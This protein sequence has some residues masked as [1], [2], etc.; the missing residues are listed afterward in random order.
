VHH[1]PLNLVALAEQLHGLGF[2]PGK[3]S[4][5]LEHNRLAIHSAVSIDH[6]LLFGHQVLCVVKPLMQILTSN[7]NSLRIELLDRGDNWNEVVVRGAPLAKMRSH[8]SGN[9]IVVAL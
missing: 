4:L 1:A 2:K 8:H 3:F 7:L 5:T 9:T 6:H